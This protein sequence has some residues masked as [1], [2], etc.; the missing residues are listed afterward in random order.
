MQLIERKVYLGE[1]WLALLDELFNE[2]NM[3]SSILDN[4]LD[5]TA[6]ENKKYPRQYT[7]NNISLGL[8]FQRR[9]AI[10]LHKSKKILL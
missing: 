7:E 3:E 1:C 5:T 4:W 10:K 6:G 9:F 8:W 2:S